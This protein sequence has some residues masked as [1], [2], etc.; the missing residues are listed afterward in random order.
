MALV[1][2][3]AALMYLVRV[4]AKLK[5]KSWGWDDWTISGAFVSLCSGLQ[6]AIDY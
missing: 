3:W 6:L 5:T 1:L 2:V 4:W